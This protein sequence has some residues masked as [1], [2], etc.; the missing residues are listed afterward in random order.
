MECYIV[1]FYYLNTTSVSKA[2]IEKGK[3]KIKKGM[4]INNKKQLDSFLFQNYE[5]VLIPIKKCTI[6]FLRESVSHYIVKAIKV[7]LFKKF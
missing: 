5:S 3:P 7:G 4:A 2:S 6:P 1:S